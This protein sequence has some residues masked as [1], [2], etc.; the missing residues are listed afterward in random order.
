MSFPEVNDTLI[1]DGISYRFTQHPEA[2]GIPYGQTGR[3][4]TVY[5]LQSSTGLHALKVFQHRFRSSSIVEGSE[6]LSRFAPLRGLR[7]C[8]RKVLTPDHDAA[9]ITKH[10]ELTYAVLM[11]WINGMSWMQIIWDRQHIAFDQSYELASA[12]ADTLAAMEMFGLAHCDL[13]NANVLLTL[14][15]SSVMLV[16]VEDLYGPGLIKPKNPPGG[17]PGYAHREAPNGLWSPLADRF[18]G[19]ILLGEMLGWCDPAVRQSRFDEQYFDPDG[20]DGSTHPN[21]AGKQEE[22]LRRLRVLLHSLTTQWSADVANTFATAW[23]SQR[24][25]DCPPMTEWARVIGACAP[26]VRAWGAPTTPQ[27]APPPAQPPP[28][29][30]TTN[31]QPSARGKPNV[32]CVVFAI[33][34]VVVI[35]IAIATR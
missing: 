29:P 3:F 8:Q 14:N 11:P 18:A 9:L 31:Q 10:S 32:G 27:P 25:S 5:Q 34:I 7:A 20:M 24:L 16:D 28:A 2:L 1:I 13:S 23:Y 15:P 22:N 33:I 30:P 19:A 21:F 6:R 35:L 26:R 17:S 4:A 12:F